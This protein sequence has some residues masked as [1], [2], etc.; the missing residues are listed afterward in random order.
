MSTK[1]E[2]L[3]KRSIVMMEWL[4]KWGYVTAGLSFLFLGMI[5]FVQGW[6]LFFYNL[7]DGVLRAA[8]H[9]M[10][11]LL[12]V[13]I[14]LE[15]F[16]TI[17]EFSK[18]HTLTLEPFIYIGIVAAIRKILTLT[19]TAHDTMALSAERFFHYLWDIGLHG[20]LVLGLIISLYIY[21]KAI[22]NKS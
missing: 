4:E 8:M 13:V 6:G 2:N 16:R 5:I 11:D 20:V 22:V 18:T 15:L 19:A 7:N 14:F 21:R 9:L 17:L 10:V 12:L 1:S 3:F